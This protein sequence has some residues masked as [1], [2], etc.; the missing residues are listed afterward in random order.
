MKTIELLLAAIITAMGLVGNTNTEPANSYE[1]EA[2]E[3]FVEANDNVHEIFSDERK[4]ELLEEGID[5]S[6]V[7][8]Y[9]GPHKIYDDVYVFRADVTIN[10]HIVSEVS[11]MDMK[12]HEEIDY[13]GL[14]DNRQITDEEIDYYQRLLAVH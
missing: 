6:A 2:Y 13:Y 5:I 12:D 7:N 4:E 10:D 9:Y 3:I 1:E 14:V 11:I 8:I